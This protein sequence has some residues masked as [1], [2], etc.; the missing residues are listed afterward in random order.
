M[1]ASFS[2]HDNYP[3]QEALVVDYGLGAFNDGAAPLSEVSPISCF[4]R[5]EAGRVVGGA[6]GRWWGTGCE[7]QQLWVEEGLR[8]QGL[9]TALLKE[10][11]A[12]A[13]RKGCKSF[14]LETFSFQAPQLYERM[15]YKAEYIRRG[16]PRGIV[17]C[18]M[19]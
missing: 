4:A 9:G 3:E 13:M 18:H 2:N 12:H 19:A 10:F 15:G 17:K 6:I 1:K 11:E 8:R 16:F 7:L 14:Y 5:D